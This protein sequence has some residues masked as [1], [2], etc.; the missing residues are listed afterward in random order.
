V[1]LHLQRCPLLLPP[2]QLLLLLLLLLRPCAS[3]HPW[4]PQN[5]QPSLTWAPLRHHAHLLQWTLLC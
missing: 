3:S 5:P 1:L 4:L 2:S